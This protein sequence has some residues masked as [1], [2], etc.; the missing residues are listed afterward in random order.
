MADLIPK[1]EQRRQENELI[2]NVPPGRRAG[3]VKCDDVH[4]DMIDYARNIQDMVFEDSVMAFM[5]Q[6]DP[7]FSEDPATMSA[8]TKLKT[9]KSAL[10]PYFM[11][12]LMLGQADP[13]SYSDEAEQILC[14]R[15]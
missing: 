8:E 13:V 7:S 5:R 12:L 15:F 6:S 4:Y 9:A 11:D 10:R 14:W 2:R 1:E 3:A